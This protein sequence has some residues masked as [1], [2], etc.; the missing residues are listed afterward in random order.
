MSESR[1]GPA[2]GPALRPLLIAAAL[3]SA[4]AGGQQYHDHEMDFGAVRTV[5]V[6][7]FANLSRDNLAGE[8]VRDVFAN[9]LLASGTMY[10]QPHGEVLRVI[11]TVGVASPTTPSIEEVLK[12]GKALKADAVITGVVK[13]Y[14][15]IRSGNTAA[16]VV[17]MST[18]MIETGT[19]K[20]VWFGSTTQGGITFTDRLFGGGGQPINDVTEAASRDL[21][22]K[23]LK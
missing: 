19:G 23:L 13:E 6:M 4:C 8:R 12:L 10:V 11:G 7:P 17:S 5:A 16:N 20:V 18:Q 21:L 2:S 15:E 1:V 22:K 9:M 14:G 3:I